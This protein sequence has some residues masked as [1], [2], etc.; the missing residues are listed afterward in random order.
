M[1]GGHLILYPR[2]AAVSQAG[3]VFG[4]GAKPDEEGARG[5]VGEAG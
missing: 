1:P 4:C 2:D 5:G 3:T